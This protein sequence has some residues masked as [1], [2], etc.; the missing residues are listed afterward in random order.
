MPRGRST[1]C[2]PAVRRE[3]AGQLVE[4]VVELDLRRPHRS[5]PGGRP[6]ERVAHPPR[7]PHGHVPGHID[8]VPNVV[9]GDAHLGVL[10]GAG[11]VRRHHRREGA[12]EG[13]LD[14]ALVLDAVRRDEGVLVLQGARQGLLHRVLGLRVVAV[15]QLLPRALVHHGLAGGLL[16][17]AVL[18]AAAHLRREVVAMGVRVAL[19]APVRLPLLQRLEPSGQT[20]RGLLEIEAL[21]VEQRCD[22]AFHVRDEDD[23][24]Q[25]EVLQE[26]RAGCGVE[27]LVNFRQHGLEAPAILRL[28]RC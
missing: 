10:D 9:Q 12:A 22:H 25:G 2:D 4:A 11:L 24:R 7:R 16:G 6:R 26:E 27:R 5:G 1:S 18:V 23:I 8:A 28:L 17:R 21:V 3:L 20:G 14:L 15:R 19:G 13:L